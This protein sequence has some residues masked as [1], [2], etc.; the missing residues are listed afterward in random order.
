MRRL[1]KSGWE[2]LCRSRSADSNNAILTQ[3]MM[4]LDDERLDRNVFVVGTTDRRDLIDVALL[5][6]GRLELQFE[7]GL[8]DGEHFDL[9]LK[10]LDSLDITAGKSKP[11][12]SIP[13]AELTFNALQPNRSRT[14]RVR[15]K[16]NSNSQRIR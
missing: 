9:A 2:A 16:P 6:P 4:L 5:R 8:P 1:R 10:N 11:N 3:L 15:S 13:N 14:N 7:I 12:L